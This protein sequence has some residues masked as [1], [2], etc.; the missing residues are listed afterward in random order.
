[1]PAFFFVFHQV[2]PSWAPLYTHPQ[3]GGGGKKKRGERLVRP[4]RILKILNPLTLL[5]RWRG[6]RGKKRGEKK[7]KKLSAKA[8]EAELRPKLSRNCKNVLS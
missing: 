4:A 6:R 7:K 8:D 5:R 2:Q 1:V 3:K